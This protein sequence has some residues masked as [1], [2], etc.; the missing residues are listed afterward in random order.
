MLLTYFCTGSLKMFEKM[1]E[2]CLKKMMKN[3]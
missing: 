1:D 3:V 2:K